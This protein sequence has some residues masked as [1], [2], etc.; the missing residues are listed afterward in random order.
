MLVSICPTNIVATQDLTTFKKLSNLTTANLLV[1]NLDLRLMI[2]DYA[3]QIL[4]QYNTRF[5]NF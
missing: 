4:L 1:F 3:S 5:D 2:Y